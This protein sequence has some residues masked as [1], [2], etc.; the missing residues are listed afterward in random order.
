MSDELR[1]EE[2]A[3]DTEYWPPCIPRNS[4]DAKMNK[5]QL[6]VID[7]IERH[8]TK[9]REQ[10]ILVTMLEEWWWSWMDRKVIDI[11]KRLSKPNREALWE[12]FAE[13]WA[14]EMSAALADRLPIMAAPQRGR[15]NDPPIGESH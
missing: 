12:L 5:D 8:F 7:Q 2:T 6:R 4:P 15:L 10:R 11:V 1:L 9:R 13:R 3:T 14:D